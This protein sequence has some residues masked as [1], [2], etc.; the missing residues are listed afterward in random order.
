[1]TE[2][3]KM[4]A[5]LPYDFWDAGVNNRKLNAIEFCRQLRQMQDAGATEA[6]QEPLIRQYFGAVGRDVCLCPGF[7]CDNGKNIFV[8]DQF[9]TNYK[10]VWCAPARPGRSSRSASAEHRSGSMPPTGRPRRMWPRGS[11]M[12]VWQAT[13]S[14]KSG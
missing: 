13:L 12:P 9:L 8:G 4:D 1:M 6:E 14:G 2:S 5:G 11:C 3:E 7:Q 10:L